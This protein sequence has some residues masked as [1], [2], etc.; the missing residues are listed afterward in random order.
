MMFKIL[1]NSQSGHLGISTSNFIH[2]AEILLLMNVY[3]SV[4]ID[5]ETKKNIKQLVI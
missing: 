5:G 4:V 2:L 1:K 3:I